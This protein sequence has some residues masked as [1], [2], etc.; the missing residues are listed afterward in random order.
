RTALATRDSAAPTL[1]G[2][3]GAFG[4]PV[5]TQRPG[6]GRLAAYP[7][8]VLPRRRGGR[9]ADEPGPRRRMLLDRVCVFEWAADDFAGAGGVGACGGGG[10]GGEGCRD[11]H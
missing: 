7:E 10:G 9:V 8:S 1:P 11:V 4:R 5:D 3:A 2:S 6:D